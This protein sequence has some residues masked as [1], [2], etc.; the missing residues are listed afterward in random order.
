[1]PPFSGEADLVF[2]ELVRR[3]LAGQP[4]SDMPG[5]RTRE[6]V[7]QE[8]A[9]GEFSRGPLV[10]DMDLLPYPDYDDYFEQFQAS[11]TAR[12]WQ[13]GLEESSYFTELLNPTHKGVSDGKEEGEE[14]ESRQK[15]GHQKEGPEAEED[16][17]RDGRRRHCLASCGTELARDLGSA[18]LLRQ[19]GARFPLASTFEH[20]QEHKE[21]Q[22]RNH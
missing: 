14:K 5:V 12:T 22:H 3:V 1:M 18:T 15:E 11:R 21:Q 9:R 8:F 10:R 4:V 13:P 2:P 17:A 20:Q 7:A 6:T 19:A 16:T